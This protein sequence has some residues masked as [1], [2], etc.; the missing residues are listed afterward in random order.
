MRGDPPAGV[1]ST[2]PRPSVAGSCGAVTGSGNS[3]CE[4]DRAI[5]QCPGDLSRDAGA[6]VDSRAGIGQRGDQAA[7]LGAGHGAWGQLGQRHVV[8]E[9]GGVGASPAAVEVLVELG[10]V[11]VGPQVGGGSQRLGALQG[12]GFGWRRQRAGIGA[13]ARR[14]RGAVVEAAKLRGGAGRGPKRLGRRRPETAAWVPGQLGW[15]VGSTEGPQRAVLG[16][17]GRREEGGL[18]GFQAVQR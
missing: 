11:H 17:R 8:R 2:R 10:Q 13:W 9:P 3:A 5:A 4:R 1:P 16:R 12:R 14:A 18:A 6:V 15:A 7:L